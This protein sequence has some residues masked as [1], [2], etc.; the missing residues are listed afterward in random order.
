[1]S[2]DCY[3]ESIAPTWRNI[4]NNGTHDCC[5]PNSRVPAVFI[6]GNDAAPANRIHIVHGAKEDFNLHM[7]SNFNAPLKQWFNITFTVDNKKMSTYF[8]GVVDNGVTGTFNWGTVPPNNW[9]WNQ[10]ID[11]YKN[12]LHTVGSVKVKNVVFWNKSL[13]DSQLNIILKE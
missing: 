13:T 9:K 2:F 12:P 10:Y 7:T 11:Q 1:M 5:D 3:I 4:F 6:S 8:N